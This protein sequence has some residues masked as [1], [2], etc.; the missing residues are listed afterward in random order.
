M[1]VS[2]LEFINRLVYFFL[3]ER[4]EKK[5][6]EMFNPL[7]FDSPAIPTGFGMSVDSW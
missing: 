5:S 2:S 6:L 3:I 4:K 7:D 1:I